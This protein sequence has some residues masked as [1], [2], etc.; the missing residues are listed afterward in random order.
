SLH[1]VLGFCFSGVILIQD[2]IIA[3]AQRFSFSPSSLTVRSQNGRKIRPKVLYRNRLEWHYLEVIRGVVPSVA[4]GFTV[5]DTMKAYLRVP[6]RDKAI[7]EVATN[8]RENQTSPLP[9][10]QSAS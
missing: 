10:S 2:R 9:S 6:P 3:F 5:Y 4:I 7:V 1:R 8:K